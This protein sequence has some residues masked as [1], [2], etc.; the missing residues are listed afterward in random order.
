MF[1]V[2]GRVQGNVRINAI[3]VGQEVAV[4]VTVAAGVAA[5]DVVAVVASQQHR[6]SRRKV[7]PAVAADPEEVRLEARISQKRVDRALVAR[8]GVADQAAAR[9]PREIDRVV[10]TSARGVARIV[11]A[12]QRRADQGVATSQNGAA[13]KAA[14]IVRRAVLHTQKKLPEVALPVVRSHTEADRE[15]LV[16][17]RKDALQVQA[18]QKSLARMT[19]RVAVVQ[20]VLVRKRNVEVILQAETGEMTV[21]RNLPRARRATAVRI[22][23]L[24]RSLI[25]VVQL[26]VKLIV[27]HQLVAWVRRINS[28]LLN[29]LRI[30]RRQ[31]VIVG[32]RATA[33]TRTAA[34]RVIRKVVW[35]V[36]TR[37]AAGQSVRRRRKVVL[38][39]EVQKRLEVEVVLAA[40]VSRDIEV[41]HEIAA[42]PEASHQA[43]T[44]T[45]REALASQQSALSREVVRQA[46]ERLRIAVVHPAMRKTRAAQQVVARMMIKR[47]CKAPKGRNYGAVHGKSLRAVTKLVEAIH[48]VLLVHA[49]GHHL[50]ASHVR[51]ATRSRITKLIKIEHCK[52]QPDVLTVV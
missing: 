51:R 24:N 38:S 7:V 9:N 11:A 14:M 36:T 30:T 40:T 12:G 1:V 28:V 49:A 4:V 29:R 43:Q 20:L 17:L 10:V 2:I 47:S 41:V 34:L 19:E 46:P 33:K 21:P 13:L 3:V 42:R 48:A 25:E 37:V 45:E 8:P 32:H 15:V 18:N 39:L 27:L 50:L 22:V 35:H 31:E 44:E 52:L 23:L 6:T 26:V 5:A 16:V